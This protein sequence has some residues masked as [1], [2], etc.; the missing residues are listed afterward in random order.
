MENKFR[1]Y[2]KEMSIAGYGNWKPTKEMVGTKSA[3]VVKNDWTEIGT[4]KSGSYVYTTY[5]LHDSYILGHFITTS[6]NDEMFEVVFSIDLREHRMTANAFNIR[7]RLMN[8]DGVMS[9]ETKRGDGLAIY[10]YK[11]LV[12][13]EKFIILGDELQYFGARRLWSRLSKHADV[14]VDIID[15]NSEKYLEKDVVLHHGSNDWEFD[16][17][18]W[19]YNHD[20]KHI[21]L[22][23]K[24]IL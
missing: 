19:S 20:K 24:D 13:K 23:L 15:T 18:V 22:L 7:N 17:R 21:R 4:V 1:D 12:K 9:A 5:K 3:V 16:A 2:I 14:T 10:M 11:L 6:S 8:V